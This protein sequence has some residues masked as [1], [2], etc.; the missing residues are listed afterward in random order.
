[1][2]SSAKGRTVHLRPRNQRG[3]CWQSHVGPAFDRL[4]QQLLAVVDGVGLED[5]LTRQIIDRLRS[6]PR[7]SPESDAVFAPT[8]FRRPT[9]H[10]RSRVSPSALK[11]SALII[12]VSPDVCE[13]VVTLGL[14]TVVTP[15]S[16]QVVAAQLKC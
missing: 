16:T 15:S 11:L 9:E 10:P 4:F 7:H 6:I 1:M 12:S 14:V 13:P 3:G 2:L 8:V 5:A